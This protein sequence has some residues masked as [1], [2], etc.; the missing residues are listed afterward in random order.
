MPTAFL[1]IVNFNGSSEETD[2]L[3]R[4]ACSSGE[5][6]R[7]Y[8]LWAD[9][10][11][12]AAEIYPNVGAE[13]FRTNFVNMTLGLNRTAYSAQGLWWIPGWRVHLAPGNHTLELKWPDDKVAPAFVID[14]V[15]LQKFGS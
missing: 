15:C 13:L 5:T 7:A 10:N 12:A 4:V 14:A 9:G 8:G 3:V 2:Y 1:G 11:P 6:L